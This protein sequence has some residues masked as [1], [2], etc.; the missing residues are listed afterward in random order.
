[1]IRALHPTDVPF[2]A[3][4]LRRSLNPQLAAFLTHA[5]VGVGAYLADQLAR[6]VRDANKCRLVAED[7]RGQPQGYAEFVRTAAGSA[8]LSY[9]CVAEAARGQGIAQ[10]LVGTY[11]G[12]K[13]NVHTI[14]LHVF[15][16]NLGAIRL[17]ERNGLSEVDRSAW[18]VRDLPVPAG[19]IK[20]L[21]AGEP[22]ATYARYGFCEMQVD[23]AGRV[24]RVGRIGPSVLRCFDRRQFADDELLGA[25][26]CRFGEL[27][28]ALTISA[29]GSGQLAPRGG[30]QLAWS[31]RMSGPTAP[32]RE[33]ARAGAQ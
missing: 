15:D 7:S 10:S 6:G 32:I 29:P 3:Q 1:M 28:Q 26:R 13:P 21:A 17:Y 16:D 25:L 11:C 19:S 24:V 9:I 33:A 18:W 30:R 14:D 23:W 22:A 20:L 12:M 8:H 5:Q 2:V 27:T 31:L 4:L